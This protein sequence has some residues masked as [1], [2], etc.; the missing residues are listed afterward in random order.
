MA[1]AEVGQRDKHDGGACCGWRHVGGALLVVEMLA[2]DG[3]GCKDESAPTLCNGA[4]KG[5]PRIVGMYVEGAEILMELIQ[6][7]SEELSVGLCLVMG[8]LSPFYMGLQV[9]NEMVSGVE[10]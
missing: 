9:S 8:R 6:V 10:R 4:G 5:G 3:D 1:Y 7:V 2:K